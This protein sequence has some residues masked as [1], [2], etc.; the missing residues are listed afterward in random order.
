MREDYTLHR[1]AVDDLVGA[2]VENSPVVPEKE[3]RKYKSKT[4]FGRIPEG[5]KMVF[6]KAWFA[7]AVCFFI[8]W[9]LSSYLADLLDVLFVF[10]IVLGMVTDLLTNNVIR[11]YAKTP[12][13]NDR[14]MMFPKKKYSSFV[15]NIMYAMLLLFCVVVLY[16]LI[17]IGLTVASK[18]AV[19]LGVGPVLFG[20]FYTGFDMLFLAMKHMLISMVEDAKKSAGQKG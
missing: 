10:G 17:N 8:F 7:G 2:N 14:F 3:L 9:G 15:F 1:K 6:F 18:E 11:Y 19:A 13:A 20:L 16:S 4:L 5:V 12:G